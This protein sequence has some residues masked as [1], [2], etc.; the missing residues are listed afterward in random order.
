MAAAAGMTVGE[1]LSDGKLKLK[2][3]ILEGLVKRD[4]R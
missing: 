2:V 4:R 1:L 3:W